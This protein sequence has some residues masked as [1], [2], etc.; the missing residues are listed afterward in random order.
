[1]SHFEVSFVY[2]I[3]VNIC[4]TSVMMLYILGCICCVAIICIHIFT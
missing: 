2:L 4:M 1:M 3:G